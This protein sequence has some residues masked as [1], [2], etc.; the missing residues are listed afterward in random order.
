MR[1]TLRLLAAAGLA[2]TVG[3]GCSTAEIDPMERQPKFKPYAETE[4][5]AD[6]R[7][8]RQW[9]EGTVPRERIIGQ[10]ALTEG[11]IGEAPVDRIPVTVDVATLR[12]GRDRYDIY[13]APCH[14]IAGDGKGIISD[15][16]AQ[17]LPPSLHDQYIRDYPVGR[18][19]K[20]IAQGYGLMPSYGYE[21]DAQDRWAVVAYVRALQRS[22]S[23]KLD[24][25]PADVRQKLEQ[26]PVPAAPTGPKKENP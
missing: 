23:A 14:G 10:P 9:P 18:I 2:S 8:M 21:L 3:A 20:A 24:E 16:V 15:K 1:P 4:L 11:Q 26:A 12:R 19:Y 5:F 25:L 6:G 17:R 13:C 7:A 22:Q